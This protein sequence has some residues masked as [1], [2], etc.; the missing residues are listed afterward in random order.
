L[1]F[2]A[3]EETLEKPALFFVED[4]VH[5]ISTIPDL[6]TDPKNPDDVVTDGVPDHLYDALRYEV[7]SELYTVGLMKVVGA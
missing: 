6:P 4:C 5:C 1:M 3:H 7:M 2:A